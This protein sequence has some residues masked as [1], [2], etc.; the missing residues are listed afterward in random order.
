MATEKMLTMYFGE[1]SFCGEPEENDTGDQSMQSQTPLLSDVCTNLIRPDGLLKTV[2]FLIFRLQKVLLNKV[3]HGLFSSVCVHLHYP[4]LLAWLALAF[5]YWP[6]ISSPGGWWA[7]QQQ[8]RKPTCIESTELLLS[9]SNQAW[10][11]WRIM[12]S[13]VGSCSSLI[14]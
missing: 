11:P 1:V 8:S 13:R 3:L 2:L 14:F 10:S 12:L 5:S 6:I 7:A 4:W 9:T